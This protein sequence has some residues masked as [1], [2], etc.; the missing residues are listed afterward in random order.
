MYNQSIKI[1]SFLWLTH[2]LPLSGTSSHLAL[3]VIGLVVGHH[4][5]HIALVPL[6]NIWSAVGKPK[7]Y[8]MKVES[9][10]SQID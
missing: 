6:D 3:Q 5:E 10:E 8:R 9:Y 2:Q 1:I 7:P 4:S